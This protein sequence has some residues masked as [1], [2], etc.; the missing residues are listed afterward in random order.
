[1]GKLAVTACFRHTRERFGYG[2]LLS[3]ALRGRRVACTGRPFFELQNGISGKMKNVASF[4]ADNLRVVGQRIY[5]IYAWRVQLSPVVFVPRTRV[6]PSAANI[7][8]NNRSTAIIQRRDGRPNNE[9]VR[10]TRGRGSDAISAVSNGESCSVRGAKSAARA[11]PITAVINRRA[12]AA[13]L[14]KYRARE[15]RRREQYGRRRNG[16]RVLTCVRRYS[17]LCPLLTQRQK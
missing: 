14:Y 2:V 5:A 7:F 1:M 16:A 8:E 6:T 4:S 9:F 10:I 3:R 15:K 13:Y 12:A 17:S 11:R